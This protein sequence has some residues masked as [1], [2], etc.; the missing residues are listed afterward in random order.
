MFG[1]SILEVAIGVTFVYLLLSLICT[2]LNEA[3]ASLLEKRGANLFEGI[4][5]LLN[6]PTFTGLAQ[7]LY[8]HGLIGGISQHASNPNEP[9]RRPSLHVTPKIFHWLCWISSVYEE[10]SAR[11]TAIFWQRLKKRM[12]LMR[13]PGRQRLPPTIISS[14]RKRPNWRS[15]HRHR[16]RRRFKR[17]QIKRRLRTTRQPGRER[18]IRKRRT[19]QARRRGKEQHGSHQCRATTTGGAPRSHRIV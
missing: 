3:I 17:L 13:K 11:N 7:Q 15:R 5:N 9:T 14:W 18:G 12:T 6:D 2:A 10:L 4:K 19:C 16:P 1:S 8:N